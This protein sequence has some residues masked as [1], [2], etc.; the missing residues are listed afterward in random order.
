VVYAVTDPGQAEGLGPFQEPQTHYV[1]SLKQAQRMAEYFNRERSDREPT[2]VR[3]KIPKMTPNRGLLWALNF[4]DHAGS[5]HLTYGISA[6]CDDIQ[7][8]D[9]IPSIVFLETGS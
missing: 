9:L 4:S 3:I 2:I 5:K 7:V 1:S 6:Y 8:V